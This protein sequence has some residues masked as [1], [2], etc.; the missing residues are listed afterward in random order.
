[1]V[2]MAPTK[3]DVSG[4]D[5]GGHSCPGTSAWDGS[6]SYGGQPGVEHDAFGGV[7]S[8]GSYG[9]Q[10]IGNAG[11]W[12]LDAFNKGKGKGDGA[13]KVLDCHRC[14]GAGHPQR[15]CPSPV[16]PD[17][18]GPRCDNCKRL[19]HTKAFCPSQGGGKFVPYTKGNGGKG[20]GTG[21]RQG[22]G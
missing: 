20:G 1:M 5:N 8:A 6:S 17:P 18:K 14:K 15:I 11:N 3:M 9:D 2:P 4:V 21:D 7:Q 13:K 16:D 10:W 22:G 19:G 12:D